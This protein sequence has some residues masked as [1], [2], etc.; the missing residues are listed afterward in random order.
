MSTPRPLNFVLTFN[1][2]FA[3][4]DDWLVDKTNKMGWDGST[5]IIIIIT[6]SDLSSD[7]LAIAAGNRNLVI[8]ENANMVQLLRKKQKI[9]SII[10]AYRYHSTTY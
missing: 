5:I 3:A 10:S 9:E 7:L 1:Q 6:Y 8:M 4:E 2:P